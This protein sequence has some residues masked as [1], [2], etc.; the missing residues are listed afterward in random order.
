[1]VSPLCG[2]DQRI[3]F[4]MRDG[5]GPRLVVAGAELTGVHLLQHKERPK[6]GAYHIGGGGVF[7]EEALIRSLGET[8]ERY[9]QLLSGRMLAE[10]TTFAS[11]S[12][13]V[14]R[15]AA[16]LPAEH[17]RFFQAAQLSSKGFRFKA[18]D[19][20][21]A[22]S[23]VEMTEIGSEREVQVPAQLV[24][25]GYRIREEDGEP[26]LST[27]VTTGTAAH[28]NPRHAL[29]NAL[30][31]LIQ[32]DTAM[33]H[34]YSRAVAPEIVLDGR[35]AAIQRIVAKHWGC[36]QQPPV[37]HWLRSP[38][39]PGFTVACI[40]R[41]KRGGIPAA[42]VGLGIDLELSEALYKAMLE[43][44]GV[45]NLAKISWLYRQTADKAGFSGA[46]DPAKIFDLDTNVVY[47]AQP[48]NAAILSS[49][50]GSERIAASAMPRDLGTDESSDLRLLTR[51]FP[52]TGKR[53]FFADVTSPEIRDLSLHVA[54]V[55]S[56]DV[57]PLSLPSA[58]MLA[59]PRY[60]R[61]GGSVFEHPH[62]YP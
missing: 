33:G 19:P 58:P 39:L 24:L 42:A 5:R 18:F 57:L 48:H 16:V 46:I 41:A 3:G 53:L 61:Y 20:D 49:K 29:R 7:L 30:L 11:F 62:P 27:A 31:E 15:G 38:D 59:H 9:S 47:Y 1:M 21:A 28:T 37:F 44:V 22:M 36:S 60:E 14:A 52:E 8:A 17:Y 50:F 32:I 51:C 23:W 35:T 2:L 6:Q 54:R 43:A 10:R 13:L 56:P 34:W 12:E 4:M 40:V 45:A 25:V 55:W 26:W